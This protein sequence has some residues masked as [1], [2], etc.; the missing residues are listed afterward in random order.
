MWCVCMCVCCVCAGGGVKCV[1]MQK[2]YVLNNVVPR[3]KGMR[4]PGEIFQAY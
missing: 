3:E 2:H 4:S 1:T